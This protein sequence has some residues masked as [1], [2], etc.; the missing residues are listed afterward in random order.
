MPLSPESRHGLVQSG[1][2][3]RHRDKAGEILGA[4]GDD[5]PEAFH[6]P[7]AVRRVMESLGNGGVVVISGP[8]GVGKTQLATCAIASIATRTVS[9][10]YASAMSIIDHVRDA[11]NSGETEGFRVN[12]W[13]SPRLLVIEEFDKRRGTEDESRIIERIIDTRYGRMIPTLILT[14]ATRTGFRNLASDAVIDRM[15]ESGMYL[16]LK[17]W[18]NLRRS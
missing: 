9:C 3:I 7:A 17:T 4:H 1:V 13:T 10:R 8:P 15:A 5:W 18:P 11:M 14:N 16:E 6:D 12:L 2:H